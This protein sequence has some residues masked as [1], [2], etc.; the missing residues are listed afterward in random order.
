[1]RAWDPAQHRFFY[2]NGWIWDYTLIKENPIVYASRFDLSALIQSGQATTIDNTPDSVRFSFPTWEYGNML[3]TEY[4][5][6][7]SPQL[8]FCSRLI[9][10]IGTYLLFGLLLF[11]FTSLLSRPFRPITELL[12]LNRTVMLMLIGAILMLLTFVAML[13]NTCS[14]DFRYLFVISPWVGFAACRGLSIYRAGCAMRTL[15]TLGSAG[16]AY[17]SVWLVYTL[18]RL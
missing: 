8:L 4:N 5:Y 3:L 6:T 11:F 14:A 15:A 9:I 12:S 7:A 10:I 1:M 2:Y 13:P 17:A 16:Y 18:Y